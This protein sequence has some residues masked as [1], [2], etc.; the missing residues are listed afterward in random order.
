KKQ[1]IKNKKTSPASNTEKWKREREAY[2]AAVERRTTTRREIEYET[3]ARGRV[4]ERQ[5]E[6][7]RARRRL[8]RRRDLKQTRSDKS[9]P[10][11]TH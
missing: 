5:E 7:R 2:M 8:Q 1:K 10:K 4:L 6:E 3:G 9:R 11:S